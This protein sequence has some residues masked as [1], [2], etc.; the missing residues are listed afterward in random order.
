MPTPRPTFDHHYWNK[1]AGEFAGH[2]PLNVWRAYMMRVYARMIDNWLRPTQPKITGYGLKTDLF[3]EAVTP[4]H[5]WDKMGCQ[6]IG[7]DSSSS[8]VRSARHRLST[9]GR[10]K[11]T[12]PSQEPLVFIADLRAIPLPAKSLA[13]IFSGSSLDHFTKRADIAA[14]LKELARVLADDGMMVV[15]FDN[16][17]NPI[18][19]LR[20]WLPYGLL[21]WLGLV[22]YFVG[23]TYTRVEARQGLEAVGLTVTDET[24]IAHAPRAPMIWLT[25]VVE[26]FR[27]PR[28]EKLLGRVLDK[29]EALEKW[30]TR[31]LTGYYLVFRAKKRADI[32]KDGERTSH[33]SDEKA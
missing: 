15:S 31:Y 17:H 5:L 8:V 22:P 10:V 21:K 9:E 11:G 24:S 23:A 30:P 2:A 16:P 29:F 12:E 13:Q 25:T 4:H 33:R 18:V 27:Q 1:I 26:R 6:S 14:S 20:N 7:L 19:R 28:V 32:S 3:E